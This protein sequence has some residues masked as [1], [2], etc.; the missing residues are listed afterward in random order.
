MK[1]YVASSWR[2]TYQQ[3]VVKLLRHLGHDVYD[4][5]NPAP[6]NYGFA[7][8]SIDPN[9]KSWTPDVY[10][11]AL[12]NPIAKDGY[13]LDSDAIRWCDAGVLVLPSG[14][15]ASFELGHIM[16]QGKPGFV[17]MPEPCEPELM[18]AEAS[19]LVSDDELREHFNPYCGVVR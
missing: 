12:K 9:W 16:G 7:W 15:S 2:N 5:R 19:I 11:K 4:F 1:I 17:Y 13:A 10:R 14:R 3:S 6:G 8:S 18:Y